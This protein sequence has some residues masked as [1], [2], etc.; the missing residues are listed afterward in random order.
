DELRILAGHADVDVPE[1]KLGA[2]LQRRLAQGVEQPQSGRGA[3]RRGQPVGR[4]GDL[5]AAER[6]QLPQVRLEGLDEGCRL[7][8]VIMTSLW[9][10]SSVNVTSARTCRF[11][12]SLT[13]RSRA[14]RRAL[15]PASRGCWNSQV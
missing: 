10:L 9:C 5:V 15:M 4:G 7:H 13:K 11:R 12:A 1:R 6:R 3:D 2:D 14:K 8:G